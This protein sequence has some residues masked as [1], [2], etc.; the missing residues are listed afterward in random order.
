MARHCWVRRGLVI[1]LGNAHIVSYGRT[2]RCHR[3]ALPAS[4]AA[5]RLTTPTCGDQIS[6]V[7]RAQMLWSMLV[8]PRDTFLGHKAR[9]RIERSYPRQP[10]NSQAMGR[11][12]CCLQHKSDSTLPL[13]CRSRYCVRV[14]HL[15]R[16]QHLVGLRSCTRA[17]WQEDDQVLRWN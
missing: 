7:D 8:P 14:S 6:M 4:C 17:T 9:P 11:P 5:A 13:L 1:S 10:M 15:R 16:G 3:E 12:I 2:P